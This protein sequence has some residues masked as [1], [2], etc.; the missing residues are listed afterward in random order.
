MLPH[1]YNRINSKSITD[2]SMV[3]RPWDNIYVGELTSGEGDWIEYTQDK[4]QYSDFGVESSDPCTLTV[5][6]YA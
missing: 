4:D 1:A 3:S 6:L 5:Y 2:M